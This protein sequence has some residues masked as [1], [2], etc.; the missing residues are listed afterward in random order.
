MINLKNIFYFLSEGS[1]TQNSM[2]YTIPF[3]L[4]SSIS[5]IDLCKIVMKIRVEK[6][7]EKEN[8]SGGFLLDGYGH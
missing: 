8:Q 7:K 4:S 2:Y 6:K 3:V 5:K 1:H